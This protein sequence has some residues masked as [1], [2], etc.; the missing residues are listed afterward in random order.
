MAACVL[1]CHA[2]DVWHISKSLSYVAAVSC[3]ETLIDYDHRDD[4]KIICDNCNQQ[5][6]SV[7]Q[8]FLGFMKN[9]GNNS[10]EFRKYSDSIYKI[11]S[12]ISHTGGLLSDDIVW[13]SVTSQNRATDW[14]AL[15][16]IQSI[17]RICM[18][19]WLMAQRTPIL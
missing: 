12:A 3:L 7:R 17:S 4:P 18:L 14:A 6:Y 9:Y 15:F 1:Y 10:A 5:I 19:N 11:R 16:R 8:K 13:D 2:N